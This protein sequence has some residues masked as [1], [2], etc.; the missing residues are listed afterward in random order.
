VFLIVLLHSGISLSSSLMSSSGASARIG[1]KVV[2][3]SSGLG[4][5]ESSSS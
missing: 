2:G 5:A 3:I 1:A 4:L